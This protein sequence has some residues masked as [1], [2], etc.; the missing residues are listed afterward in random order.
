MKRCLARPET[1]RRTYGVVTFNSQQ[2]AL[3]QDL[4]DE[5]QRRSPELEWFFSDNRIEPTAVKNLENVQ[6]DERDVMLFSITF[7]FDESGRFPIDF[8]AINRSGG[9]RRLNVAVTRARQELVV[10]ASFSPD[11]LHAER[12]SARG[13]QDLK[14]FLEY[15]DNGVDTMKTRAGDAA[16]CSDS[17]LQ[18]AIAA[19][20]ISRGWQIDSQVGE[21][22]FRVDLGV[23][24]PDKAGSYLAGVECDGPTY[25]RSAAARD[26]DKT[27]HQTLEGLGWKIIRVWSPDWWYDPQSAIEQLLATLDAELVQSRSRA[28]AEAAAAAAAIQLEAIPAEDAEPPVNSDG[29]AAREERQ[30]E[31]PCSP[32]FAG[33]TQEASD[34]TYQRAELVDV[35][36]HQNRFFEADY[37]GELSAMAMAVL[38][39]ESP[40]RD[41][42]LVRQVARA[43]GF[44]RTSANIKRRILDVLSDA[45]VTEESTGR[46]LWKTPSPLPSVVFRFPR[47]GEDRRSVDE[48]ALAELIGLVRCRSDLA[49]SDDP[50]L[51]FAREIGLA[52]LARSARDRLEEALEAATIP[53]DSL[54]GS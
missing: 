48:I 49:A 46:F 21:S 53:V 19:A 18:E 10:F 15:A 24:H 11:Q 45:T 1:E 5:A 31:E 43:H 23:V 37:T 34:A 27:R 13:V 17:S 25:L 35:S 39:A 47:A 32:R 16:K 12:S 8:G 14:A 6:G 22:G 4:F 50:A 51:A 3:I 29:S 30:D 26:R 52:R 38:E 44:A 7:G 42:V 28:E 2:Q 40:I 54:S 9:E 36:A 41:D 20:L 33:Q